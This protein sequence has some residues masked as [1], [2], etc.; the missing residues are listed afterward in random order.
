MMAERG[1][2]HYVSWQNESSGKKDYLFSKIWNLSGGIG[3]RVYPHGR[4]RRPKKM[5]LHRADRD[6]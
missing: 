6:W 5:S 2:K 3:A 1:G 4:R